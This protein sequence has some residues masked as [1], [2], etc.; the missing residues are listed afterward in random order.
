VVNSKFVGK[1]AMNQNCTHHVIRSLFRH[2]T[3][4]F[5]SHTFAANTVLI[6]SVSR[7]V[8]YSLLGRLRDSQ[9][10]LLHGLCE[11]IS[12]S[13]H[14]HEGVCK[15][16]RTGRLE[17]GIQ[18]VQFSATMCSCITILWVSLVSFAAIAL[19]VASQWVFIFVNVYFV[20]DSVRKLLDTP[21]Y[22]CM[23]TAFVPSMHECVHIFKCLCIGLRVRA[24]PVFAWISSS[25]LLVC[26]W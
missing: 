5:K 10:S 20:I 23:L 17:R 21:S 11:Y 19:C 18:M 7:L 22:V 13:T 3:I 2:V 1:V 16:F 25:F 12:Q 6:Q 24:F 8:I 4:I 26:V 9:S 15:S 14:T